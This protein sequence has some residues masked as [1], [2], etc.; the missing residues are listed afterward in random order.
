MASAK[1]KAS[2]TVITLQKQQ[3]CHSGSNSRS[4]RCTSTTN[5]NEEKDPSWSGKCHMG[6]SLM[7]CWPLYLPLLQWKHWALVVRSHMREQNL[8][9]CCFICSIHLGVGLLCS[10]PLLLVPL[11]NCAANLK[12][13]QE[14][15]REWKSKA[16]IS[17]DVTS[18]NTAETQLHSYNY[19]GD[20][21]KL[22]VEDDP[23]LS[24]DTIHIFI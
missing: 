24:T 19:L 10:I 11:L 18:A 9:I 15:T 16:N 8:R 22:K 14:K 4:D 1:S 21:S 17:Q 3:P 13:K 2:A 12:K 5:R 7:V 6:S 20:E 23:S